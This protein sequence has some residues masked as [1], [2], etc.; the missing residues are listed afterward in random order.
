MQIIVFS[1]REAEDCAL[2]MQ[3]VDKQPYLWISIT[4]TNCSPAYPYK[5]ENC[6]G[7][8]ELKFDDIL[9]PMVGPNGLKY[10]LFT[11]QQ[12]KDIVDFVDKHRENVEII[13]VH[14]YAGISRSAG[15]GA[16]ISLYLNGDD[17]NI[18]SGFG[19][20]PNAHVKSLILA[21]IR[22]RLID[23]ESN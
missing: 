9:I 11:E 19:F 14:C 22:N 2:V 17:H 16:A 13:C 5:N 20:Q 3:T 8:L 12:A 21:E 6:V 10:K 7:I 23:H 15:V 1:Q 18:A 4:G